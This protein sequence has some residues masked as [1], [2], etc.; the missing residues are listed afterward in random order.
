ML[1]LVGAPFGVGVEQP[2]DRHAVPHGLG[3]DLRDIRLLDPL[4]EDALGIYL[5]RRA[6]LAESV[7]PGDPQLHLE[8]RL[9]DL[10]AEGLRQ[11]ARPIGAAAGAGT[12]RHHRAVRIVC[13]REL[14]AVR[15]EIGDGSES[16]FHARYSFTVLRSLP[17]F[18]V[19]NC[20]WYS[21]SM[22]A[23]GPRAQAPT[24]LTVSR[25]SLRSGVVSPGAM[26]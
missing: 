15:L 8:V 1:A 16:F 23:S 4:V 26:P 21:P 22:I 7:A 18:C 2:L 11:A 24:Q 20:P 12:D 25:V 6:S 9:V 5:H 10:L 17:S 3:E 19:L 13:G 14:P